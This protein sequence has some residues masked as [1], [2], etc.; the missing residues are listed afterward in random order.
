MKKKLINSVPV[1]LFS[2][3]VTWIKGFSKANILPV[4]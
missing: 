4:L 1:F 3:L 2:I